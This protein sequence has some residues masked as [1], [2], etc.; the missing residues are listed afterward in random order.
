MTFGNPMRY[1]GLTAFIAL[2]LTNGVAAFTLYQ[3]QHPWRSKPSMTPEDLKL[4]AEKISIPSDYI[5]LTGWFIPGKSNR[6]PHK[7]SY[8]PTAILLHGFFS[9]SFKNP[10][11]LY[12]MKFFHELGISSLAYDARAHGLSKDKTSTIGLQKE[13]VDWANVYQWAKENGLHPEIL[14]GRSMRAAT[15]LKEAKPL[16]ARLAI[17]DCPYAGLDIVLKQDLSNFTHLPFSTLFAY[18]ILAQSRMRGLDPRQNRPM[19]AAREPGNPRT[20]LIHSE[21]DS[22]LPLSHSYAIYQAA[23]Q[24]VNSVRLLVTGAKGHS[25]NFTG[26]PYWKEP[27]PEKQAKYKDYPLRYLGAIG[28][29]LML[30]YG[31]SKEQIQEALANTLDQVP[32]FHSRAIAFRPLPEEYKEGIQRF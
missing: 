16:N 21:H 1:A 11:A 6:L 4:S 31:Y 28:Q 26:Y 14:Y 7:Q 27:P 8:L 20:L 29:E 24:R 19:D 18:E 2:A 5:R 22:K 12:V 32:T 23:R 3:L 13:P 25:S 30:T 15:A 10:S 17:L 9:S